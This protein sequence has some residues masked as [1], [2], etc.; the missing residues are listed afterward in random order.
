VRNS[1]SPRVIIA[2]MKAWNER[3]PVGTVFRY[4]FPPSIT[5]RPCYRSTS[6]AL[7]V[8]S[9]V[10]R[11]EIPVVWGIR[12]TEYDHPRENPPAQILF[13]VRR[14]IPPEATKDH[15]TE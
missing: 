7:V 3:H 10:S 8:I 2:A 11:R 6:P 5:S 4:T 1:T 13:D 15:P 9:A 14:C 12:L